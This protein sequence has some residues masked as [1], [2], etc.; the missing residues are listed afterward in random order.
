[1]AVSRT[2]YTFEADPRMREARKRVRKG[3]VTAEIRHRIEREPGSK[4]IRVPPKAGGAG[5]GIAVRFR[6]SKG[7]LIPWRL[8]DR[9]IVM[10]RE[11]PRLLA[12]MRRNRGSVFTKGYEI[13]FQHGGSPVLYGKLRN[14]AYA[15][16]EGAEL[17]YGWR[18]KYSYQLNYG[19]RLPK[20]KR[21]KLPWGEWVT[22]KAG[23]YVRGRRFLENNFTRWYNGF[24]RRL[25][26]HYRSGRPWSEYK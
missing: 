3:I 4:G 26:A 5:G 18:A 24:Q 17:R 20:A 25:L 22:L 9:A 15:R 23:H 6:R 8:A 19:H 1:M 11:A 16:A 13:P 7:D 2:V 12:Q 10:K 14:S 21:F